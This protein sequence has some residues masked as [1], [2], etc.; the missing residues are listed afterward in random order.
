MPLFDQTEGFK[1]LRDA[2]SLCEGSESAY[3]RQME[4]QTETQAKNRIR[5]GMGA[6]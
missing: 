3:M 2:K 4:T 1:I 5:M 6:A